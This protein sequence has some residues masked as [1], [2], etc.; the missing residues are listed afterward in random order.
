MRAT[1]RPQSTPCR[2]RFTLDCL[3]VVVDDVGQQCL[4]RLGMLTQAEL[5]DDGLGHRDD[6]AEERAAILV[7]NEVFVADQQGL[8]VEPRLRGQDRADAGEVP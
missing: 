1:V 5:L 4:H 8:Q 7:L 2:L 6:G 3:T